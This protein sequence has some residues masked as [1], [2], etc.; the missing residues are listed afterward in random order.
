MRASSAERL[1]VVRVEER[2]LGRVVL[3]DERP[4]CVDCVDRTLQG[5]RH[6]RETDRRRLVRVVRDVRDARIL[7][8]VTE[9]PDLHRENRRVGNRPINATRQVPLIHL[10]PARHVWLIGHEGTG[11]D[12]RSEA[13]V[14]RQPACRRGRRVQ[15]REVGA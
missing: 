5:G 4:R 3:V 10:V 9:L 14:V 11:K 13:V 6:Q 15:S 8:V 1:V 12:P 7:V 2:L